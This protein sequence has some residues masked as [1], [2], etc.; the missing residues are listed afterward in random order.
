M[1]QTSG[2]QNAWPRDRSEV[3]QKMFLELVV[4][5][6]VR[7]PARASGVVNSIL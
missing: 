4:S 2:H 6:Q 1:N 3:K 5:E 7:T